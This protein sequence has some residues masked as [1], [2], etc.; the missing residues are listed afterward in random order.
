MNDVI[1]IET[2]HKPNFCPTCGKAAV[3]EVVYGYPNPSDFED[4]AAG[5]LVLG[6]CCLGNDDPGWRCTSCEQDIHRT[7]DGDE[8]EDAEDAEDDPE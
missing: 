8:D 1:R 3:V 4:A 2:T 5:T 7:E 6:G